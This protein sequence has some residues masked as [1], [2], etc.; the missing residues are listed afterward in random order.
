LKKSVIPNALSYARE[1]GK[2]QRTALEKG[3]NPINEII[4]AGDGFHLF[5]GTV[6]KDTEWKIE[7]G[8]TYGTI[9]IEGVEEYRGRSMRIWFKNEN[10]MCWLDDKVLVTVPDLICVVET[11]TG[12]PVTNPYC[13]KGMKVSVLGFKAP[14]IWRTEKGLSVLNPRYFGFEVDYVPIEERVRGILI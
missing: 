14:E 11:E 13:R 10:I 5:D 1:V 4:A 9:E 8:F 7:G 12:Y 2:A 3:K 6:K